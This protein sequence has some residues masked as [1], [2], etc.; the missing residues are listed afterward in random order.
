VSYAGGEIAKWLAA[1]RAMAARDPLEDFG[2]RLWLTRRSAGYSQAALAAAI[3]CSPSSVS[4]WE[5]A[6]GPYPAL[7]DLAAIVRVLSAAPWCSAAFLVGESA[8]GRAVG[9]A[10]HTLGR[11]TVSILVGD[12]QLV[13]L[14]WV[15][16]LGNLFDPDIGSLADT[17]SSATAAP[18]SFRYLLSKG[19]AMTTD[20]TTEP[21]PI[22]DPTDPVDADEAPAAPPD[23]APA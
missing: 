11:E 5:R 20:Q 17:L 10:I 19:G 13:Q 8:L 6:V 22:E 15:E 14:G 18:L 21:E 12:H 3:G 9:D 1:Q 7:D 2:A 23:G 16:R 4:R